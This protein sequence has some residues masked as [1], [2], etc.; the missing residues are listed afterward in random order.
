MPNDRVSIAG[1]GKA[2][3][4][5]EQG[6]FE[7][8]RFRGDEEPELLESLGRARAITFAAAGQGTGAEIDLSPEDSHYH[9]LVIREGETGELVGAYRL[10]LTEEIIAEHGVAGL[11]LDHVFEIDPEFY[12]KIGPAME[13]SRSF[14]MPHFQKDSRALALLWQG[15]GKTATEF[16]CRN[17]F[18]SVTISDAFQP[19]SRAALAAH[20]WQEH[21][22][23]EEFRQL[24]SA[25]VPF[26]PQTCYH[27][28][29]N[30]AWKGEPAT[31]LWPVVGAIERGQRTPPPLIK[32][33]L[34]LGAKFIDF[35][36]EATFGDALYCLLRMDLH[37]M[38]ERYKKRFL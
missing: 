37:A 21:A 15:L 19:A 17:L 25:R 20:L 22:D 27:A 5:I 12:E 36:V 3:P 8:L 14:V 16:G 35:H 9:H 30:E 33:Y 28:L 32:Y 6:G 2:K 13:L 29:I 1:Q 26:E 4:F 18:G 34:S 24:V 31:A 7:L 23:R 10:G 11:Y 38:P